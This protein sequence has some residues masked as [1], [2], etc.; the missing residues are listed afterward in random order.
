MVEGDSASL[1]ELCVLISAMADVPLR[2]D[3]AVTGSVNQHGEVQPVGGVNSEDRRIFRFVPL[4]RLYGYP[5]ST[6]SRI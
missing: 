2:Q 6:D 4:S 1:A 5:G 3:I